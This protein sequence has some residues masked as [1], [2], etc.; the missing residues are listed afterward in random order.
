MKRQTAVAAVVL[1]AGAMLWWHQTPVRASEIVAAVPLPEMVQSIQLTGNWYGHRAL[2]FNIMGRRAGFTS[3]SVLN[4]VVEFANGTAAIPILTGVEPL[5]L[6]SSSAQDAPAGSGIQSVRV[7]YIDATNNIVESAAIVLNGTTP[8]AAGFTAVEPLWMDS[9]AAGSGGTGNTVAAGNIRLRVV[10]GSVECEQISAG[11][12][13]SLSGR[14]MVPTGYTAYIPYWNA[15]AI[16]NDQDIRL[17]AQVTTL[18]RTLSALYHFIDTDYLPLN[19]GSISYPPFLKLPALAKI[20]VST[21]SAAT[22]AT[23]RV[24]VTFS[25]VLIAN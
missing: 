4:D 20:K 2:A 5:E 1:L 15:H 21:L 14:F 17:R 6:V 12:N 8:V 18:N 10:S 13:K 16:N 7:T 24:D 25:V 22:G 23:I 3:T 9:T 19:T 11:G